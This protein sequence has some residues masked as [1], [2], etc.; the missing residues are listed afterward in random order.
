MTLNRRVA[1]SEVTVRWTRGGQCGV[2]NE[3]SLFL[4]GGDVVVFFR[5]GFFACWLVYSI[6]VL[7]NSCNIPIAKG[8]QP[9]LQCLQKAFSTFS[10][11][12]NWL[13]PGRRDAFFANPAVRLERFFLKYL[14][15]CNV[16][17]ISFVSHA[18]RR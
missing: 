2:R 17:P 1:S 4:G 7:F 10:T 11:F 8:V 5:L 9:F 6:H 3:M 12:N 13:S 15:L 16:T 14:W 18:Q